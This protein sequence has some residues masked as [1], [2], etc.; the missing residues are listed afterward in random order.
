MQIHE[1]IYI[2]GSGDSGFGISH[3]L[4][5]TVYLIDGDGEYALIDA[6]AGVE[7]ESILHNIKAAGIHPAQISGIF[8]THGHGDHSG[9][10][11]ALSRACQAEVYALRE[12][13]EYVSEGNLKAI[14]LEE[15]IRAGVYGKGYT[16]HACPVRPILEDTS[17]QVG[18]IRLNVYRME[19]HCSGHTCYE[20]IWQGKK[21]VFS[22]DCIF[23]YGKIALQAIW[24]CDLQKYI[25]S[26][27]RLEEIHPDVLL[28]AH[29]SFLMSRGYTYIEKAMRKIRGLG[30]P[31]NLIGE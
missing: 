10:A 26:C 11:F 4:D 16:F 18:D 17:V 29:G 7:P 12:T 5:C 8:L 24:D 6:G 14:A 1:R 30:I 15:A 31:D 23:N 9:G 20:M 13:A 28:P 3:D 27:K 25:E 21:I 22:G 19:G 2:V